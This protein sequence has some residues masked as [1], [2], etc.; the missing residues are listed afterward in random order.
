MTDPYSLDV[1]K[2]L[3]GQIDMPARLLPSYG[4]H[5][6]LMCSGE[7]GSILP[8]IAAANF[9]KQRLV[10]DEFDLPPLELW[11][12]RKKYKIYTQDQKRLYNRLSHWLE[13]CLA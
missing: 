13:R 2:Q 9:P 11:I 7:F 5:E 6:E 12:C 10:D 1:L 8:K 4:H 3:D